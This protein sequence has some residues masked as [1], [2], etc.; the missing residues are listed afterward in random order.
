VY[1]PAAGSVEATR[2]GVSRAHVILAHPPHA[3]LPH[4]FDATRLRFV[5]AG[6]AG[7]EALVEAVG[8]RREILQRQRA[9][10]EEMK[11]KHE[12]E[13]AAMLEK[14]AALQRRLYEQSP[15]LREATQRVAKIEKSELDNLRAM[16]RPPDAIKLCLEAVCTLL[17]HQQTLDWARVMRIVT[18]SGFKRSILEFDAFSNVTDELKRRLEKDY[19]S[20]SEW[21]HDKMDRAYYA[22]GSLSRWIEA[23]LKLSEA[24]DVLRPLMEEVLS[25]MAQIDELAAQIE[26]FEFKERRVDEDVKFVL[27]RFG[28]FFGPSLADYSL[29]VILAHERGLLRFALAQ[30]DKV[31]ARLPD[32]SDYVYRTLG[33]LSVTVLGLGDV[34][35]HVA[36]LL[37]GAGVKRV[38]A[39]VRSRRSGADE[40]KDRAAA[41][42]LVVCASKFDGSLAHALKDADY[43][44]NTLPSTETTRDLLSGNVLSQCKPGGAVLVNVGRGDIIDEAS[45]LTALDKGWLR[46]AL[47]D[48]FREEP[49]PPESPLWTHPKIAITP[50]IA[51]VTRVPDLVA[52]FA[53]NLRRF[54][55]SQPPRFQVD[56][57]RGY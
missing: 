2:Y 16:K 49:L 20:T 9:E 21:A 45:L 19:L 28:G 1:A 14:R 5:Q 8:K 32:S 7:V 18:S 54:V 38:C 3:L 48:V 4:L 12:R 31:W 26:R 15:L 52:L 25:T 55:A 11:R 13:R 46:A 53:E 37:R 57:A 42:E 39:L 40:E 44:I 17:G 41:H 36:K 30:R 34:G 51:G 33:E 22:C 56:F 35:S 27:A 47:L 6:Y 50:H 29:G 23:Q 10:Y 24:T 43:V